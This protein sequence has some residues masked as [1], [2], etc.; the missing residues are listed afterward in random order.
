MDATRCICLLTYRQTSLVHSE[1]AV[2]IAWYSWCWVAASVGDYPQFWWNSVALAVFCA[3]WCQ[4][5]ASLV[6]GGCQR[7]R[8]STILINLRP[9]SAARWSST[10]FWVTHSR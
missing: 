9:S 2:F 7:S 10:T 6:F 4:R 3:L 8:S 1:L 5:L